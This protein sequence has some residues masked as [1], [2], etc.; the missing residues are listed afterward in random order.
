MKRLGSPFILS[1]ALAGLMLVG[2]GGG[3]GNVSGGMMGGGL[4]ATFTPDVP[5]PTAGSISM[6]AGAT[7][8]DT[9]QVEIHVTDVVDFF[10]AAFS[11]RFDPA[12]AEYQSFDT[13]M[14]MLQAYAPDIEIRAD[15]D[16]V[17]T[18]LVAIV[19]TLRNP[20]AGPIQGIDTTGAMNDLL[21][22]LT[23]RATN[24]TVGPNHNPFS[25][26]NV[27]MREIR[28]CPA[29]PGACTVLGGVNWNG[30]TLTA[31]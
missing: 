22:T 8:G 16:L 2:C 6:A 20:I 1:I 18:G 9:F 31:M 5:M 15:L 29:P 4:T 3:G 7:T 11:L 26:D 25:V 10:G 27:R 30:G 17:D 14:S 13:S 28:T 23:F 21:L 24:P 19:A 12:S